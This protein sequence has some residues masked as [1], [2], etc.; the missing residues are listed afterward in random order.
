VKRSALIRKVVREYLHR[1]ARSKLARELA[2]GYR[3]NGALNRQISE[4][5][6]HVDADNL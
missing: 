5:F 2:E 3:A 4:E 1:L 6:V